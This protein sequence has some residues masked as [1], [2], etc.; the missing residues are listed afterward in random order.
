MEQR[1]E[2]LEGQRQ[3]A[4][5]QLIDR[6]IKIADLKFLLNCAI[7][8]MEESLFI[9]EEVIAPTPI[10]ENWDS[11]FNRVKGFIAANKD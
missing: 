3:S 7:L 11:L 1:I 5:D 4:L 9:N 6:D 10:K 8:L 2:K